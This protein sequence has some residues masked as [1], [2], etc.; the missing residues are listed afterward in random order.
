MCLGPY[1]I[2]FL[3]LVR[4]YSTFLRSISV[5][6][7]S[8]I[9]HIT[10]AKSGSLYVSGRG[11]LSHVDDKGI[12]HHKIWQTFSFGQHTVTESGDLLFIKDNKVCKLNTTGEI[13][14]LF[15]L[16]C[17]SISIFSSRK[18][19]NILLGSK[20]KLTRYSIFG[21]KLCDIVK[22]S[23]GQDLYVNPVYITEQRNGNI[24]VSDCDKRSVVAVDQSGQYCFEYKGHRSESDFH[25]RGICSDL[26]GNILVCNSSTDN[27][28]VH[29]LD[30]SGHFINLLLTKSELDIR[31]PCALCLKD[32]RLVFVGYLQNIINVYKYPSDA[33]S[34]KLNR[35]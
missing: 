4:H 6:S 35:R 7:L 1:A 29:L 21:I 3:F 18:S 30:Q 10:C 13:K 12:E 15:T 9:S 25:P 28:S 11:G 17:E 34:N 16:E 24:A 19:E 33:I 32:D 26:S 2:T 20:R 8:I 14:S 31:P 5:S 23:E 22:D 27:A